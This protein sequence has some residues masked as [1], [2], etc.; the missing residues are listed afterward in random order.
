[1]PAAVGCF[2]TDTLVD[3]SIFRTEKG[4]IGFLKVNGKPRPDIY[5]AVQLPTPC[6]GCK[7]HN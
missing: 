6:P 7:M 5:D 1:M 3:H 4:A 2:I